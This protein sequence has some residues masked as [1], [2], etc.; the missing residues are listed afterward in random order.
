MDP[1]QLRKILQSGF[2]TD[3]LFRLFHPQHLR[4]VSRFNRTDE[5]GST[6]VGHAD[7][8]TGT[9]TLR[10]D[11]GAR[12]VPV[13]EHEVGHLYADSL[14]NRNPTP[15]AE[16]RKVFATIFPA[17]DSLRAVKHPSI[18]QQHAASNASELA[19]TAFAHAL[20]A[21][22][23]PPAQRDS[24]IAAADKVIPG[25]AAFAKFLMQRLKNMP[26]ASSGSQ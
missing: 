21:I 10:K 7:P 12:A 9:V 16:D 2:V 22:R 3:T 6:I 15:S 13:L 19:A 26:L 18:E 11:L 4:T 1:D 20:Q 5:P 25:T 8:K 24:A 23:L 14:F 17:L